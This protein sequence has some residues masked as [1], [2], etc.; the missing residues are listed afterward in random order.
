MSMITSTAADADPSALPAASWQARYAALRSRQVG[1]S[2][3]RIAE[4][5]A[6]LT[7]WRCKR[8][9]D[10]EA[11]QLS[12]PAAHSLAAMLEEVWA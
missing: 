8:V 6:A 12:A 3:P 4:C 2:D 9:L 1:D 5:L 11:D 7:F 10:R